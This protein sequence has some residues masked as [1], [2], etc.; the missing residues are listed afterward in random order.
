MND[1][2]LCEEY[3]FMIPG[4]ITVVKHTLMNQTSSEIFKKFI[5]KLN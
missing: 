5:L 2:Y 4:N 1:L 3:N